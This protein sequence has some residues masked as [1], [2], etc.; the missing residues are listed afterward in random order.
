MKSPG[1]SFFLILILALS[2]SSV[3]RAQ[4]DS[5]GQNPKYIHLGTHLAL[6]LG[7]VIGQYKLL[8]G[9]AIQVD[10]PVKQR[11]V[12]L[13]LNAAYQEFIRENKASS[14]LKN[15]KILP[16]KVGVKLFPVEQVY[17]QADLGASLVLN[18]MLASFDGKAV[19]VFSN[20]LGYRL[21]IPQRECCRSRAGIP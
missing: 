13:T 1:Y 7:N 14:N 12:F 2:Q 15:P 20:E 21:A 19:L 8:L 9:G 3:A 4:R 17:L 11:V 10:F 16:L 5:S 6:P 18:K